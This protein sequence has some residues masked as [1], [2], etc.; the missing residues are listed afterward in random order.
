MTSLLPTPAITAVATLNIPLP[1]DN[2][3]VEGYGY[4]E[5]PLFPIGMATNFNGS[6][7]EAI[8]SASLLSRQDSQVPGQA[9][10]I[11]NARQGMMIQKLGSSSMPNG[12]SIDPP[13]DAA[14]Y[15]P[16]SVT[17]GAA[18]LLAVVGGRRFAS[19]EGPDGAIATFEKIVDG[20]P[21]IAYP[22][23]PA[24]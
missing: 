14:G 1:P 12:V 5:V 13:A 7:G 8:H 10:G 21:G 15:V 9:F 17:I 22:P 16:E 11:F 24:R 3:F 2:P 4:K 19:F 6:V 23:I 18:G 20:P